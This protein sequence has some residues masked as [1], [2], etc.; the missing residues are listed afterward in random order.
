MNIRLIPLMAVLMLFSCTSSE[1]T[2]YTYSQSAV[3]QEVALTPQPDSVCS[4]YYGDLFYESSMV[5]AGDYDQDSCS[6]DSG[7]PLIYEGDGTLLGIVSWGPFPCASESLPYGVHTNVY[8][9]LD[10]IGNNSTLTTY[11]T[12]VRSNQ[13]EYSDLSARIVGG[14]DASLDDY[15]YFVALMTIY[16]S[17]TDYY[18]PFCGGTYLGDGLIITAAHC[19]NDLSDFASV[20]IVIGNNSSDMAYEV[21]TYDDDTIDCTIS[22]DANA[23]NATGAIVYTGS[24]DNV[25]IADSM[26]IVVHEN[27]DEESYE[28]DIALI[29]LSMVPDNESLA[30]PSSDTFSQLA[31]EG[32]QNSVTVIGHGYTQ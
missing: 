30:L 31:D 19:V 25:Y 18:Y 17:Y 9:Y 7:G 21:C 10:W 5:C 8:S 23:S 26:D 1:T 6:G 24:R 4:S 2:E 13:T 3:L 14:T 29:Q 28:N 27:Y 22:S 11:S 32:A 16:P 12:N 15:D 20:Y